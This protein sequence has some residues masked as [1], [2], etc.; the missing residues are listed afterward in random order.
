M[1]SRAFKMKRPKFERLVTRFASL[2][3]SFIYDCFVVE[4]GQ[5][6]KMADLDRIESIYSS[7]KDA[8]YCVDVTF[9]K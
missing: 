6:F 3:S 4:F 7:F 2:I 9:Q 1:L 5:R 8:L